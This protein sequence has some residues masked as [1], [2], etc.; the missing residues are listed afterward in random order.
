MENWEHTLIGILY[1]IMGT[2]GYFLNGAG[3]YHYK[4]QKERGNAILAF[5]AL[6]NIGIT[7]FAF[8]ISSL[9]SIFNNWFW[10]DFWCQYYGS[11]ALI[12]G[13]NAM[14]V[15][16]ML[17]L[18]EFFKKNDAHYEE[19]KHTQ[20]S[21]MICAS[22]VSGCFWGLAPLF[23]WSK[24]DYEPSGLSCT[25]WE[26]KPTAGYA[27]YMILCFSFYFLIPLFVMIFSKGNSKPAHNFNQRTYKETLWLI[28]FFIAEWAPYSI[29][30]IWPIFFDVKYL[31]MRLSAI[32]PL[33]AK[34][35]IVSTPI[36]YFNYVEP[37][38]KKV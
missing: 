33:L 11:V 26:E 21:L 32:G 38:K 23:G 31:P 22:V 30:Y 24:I 27:L 12:F 20:I 37:S 10:S 36:I 17:A 6:V 5:S 16:L 8:P 19:K 34:V 9:A 18:N 15:P 7:T 4:K 25:V 13:F 35:S 14:S 3:L 2:A 29:I 28:I 1:I